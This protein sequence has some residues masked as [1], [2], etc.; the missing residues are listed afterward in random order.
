MSTRAQIQFE[1]LD[2]YLYKHGDGYP[3]AVLPVLKPFV[4]RFFAARGHDPAYALARCVQELTNDSDNEREAYAQ[5]NMTEEDRV[6]YGYDKPAVL[7]FGVDD[8]LHADIEYLYVVTKAG[9][10]YVFEPG[11]KFSASPKLANMKITQRVKP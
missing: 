4:K 11:S 7:G 6:R 1:G 5:A 8:C 3:D 10:I 9:E 2:V